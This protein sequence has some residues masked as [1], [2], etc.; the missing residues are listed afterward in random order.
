LKGAS[1][2]ELLQAI[3]SVIAGKKYFSEP[4]RETLSIS[5]LDRRFSPPDRTSLMK[6]PPFLGWVPDS[7][8]SSTCLSLE[9]PEEGV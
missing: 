9:Q 3:R 5:V 1:R 4:D 2:A 8:I 7:H 6:C